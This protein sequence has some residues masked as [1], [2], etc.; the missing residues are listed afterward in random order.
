MTFILKKA[1]RSKIPGEKTNFYQPAIQIPEPFSKNIFNLKE[2]TNINDKSRE[3]ILE[4]IKESNFG[5][6]EPYE[7]GKKI[8]NLIFM[9]EP[10]GLVVLLI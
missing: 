7:L 3:Y 5:F 6:F 9:V 8:F 10:N 4:K 2:I 1:P